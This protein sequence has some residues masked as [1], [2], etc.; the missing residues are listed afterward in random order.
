MEL[1][2]ILTLENSK[3]YVITKMLT[4]NNKDYL[5]L[6]EV[7]NDENLLEEKLVVEKIID[8]EGQFVKEID[9]DNLKNIISEKFARMLL[10]DLN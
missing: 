1:Y 9:D 5:L 7:D 4:Y 2:D 10:E 6:I 3:D 8:S